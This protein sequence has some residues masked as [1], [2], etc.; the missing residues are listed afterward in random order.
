MQL[1]VAPSTVHVFVQ[2]CAVA[3]APN[4]PSFSSASE[5]GTIVG[6][7][8]DC[9]L[10]HTAALEFCVARCKDMLFCVL[11]RAKT[12]F[13]HASD[14]E[15]MLT[16]WPGSAENDAYILGKTILCSD[17]IMSCLSYSQTQQKALCPRMVGDGI[18]SEVF[19]CIQGE[20]WITNY[21]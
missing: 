4:S 3:S 2:C 17:H 15:H 20:L 12:S 11:L 13:T 14:G 8:G 9:G 19:H 21:I 1:L 18:G 16:S 7:G 6:E 5:L 10:L